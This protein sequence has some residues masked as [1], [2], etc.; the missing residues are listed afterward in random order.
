MAERGHRFS[1]K[2]RLE[3]Q[4]RPKIWGKDLTI[5]ES[6][7]YLKVSRDESALKLMLDRISDLGFVIISDVPLD[8]SF[9]ER[10]PSLI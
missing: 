6:M 4:P 8:A 5:P 1:H 2:C 9:A 3:R 10:I 7:S